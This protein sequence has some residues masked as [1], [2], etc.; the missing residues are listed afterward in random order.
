MPGLK[1]HWGHLIKF[2]ES[3]KQNQKETS[4]KSRLWDEY[5]FYIGVHSP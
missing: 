1:P 3:W 5:I 2:I 4:Q